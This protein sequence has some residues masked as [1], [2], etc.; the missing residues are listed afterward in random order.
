MKNRN[1]N[2]LADIRKQK[3]L[4]PGKSIP[5]TRKVIQQ[6]LPTSPSQT[7]VKFNAFTTKSIQNDENRKSIK[8]LPNMFVL[9][10]I[11][12]LAIEINTCPIN[13]GKASNA[14]QSSYIPHIR[15]AVEPIASPRTGFNAGKIVFSTG[16]ICMIS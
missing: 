4:M 9:I 2:V 12:T 8:S 14:F 5:A 16:N 3:V 15:Y 1:P 10:P 7:S 6:M 11:S 13:L